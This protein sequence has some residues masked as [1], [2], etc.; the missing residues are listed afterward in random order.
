M[1]GAARSTSYYLEA[2][3][4]LIRQAK[5]PPGGGGV[6]PRRRGSFTGGLRASDRFESVGRCNKAAALLE[7]AGALYL[8]V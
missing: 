6:L 5:H 3:H 1:A 8:R 2:V 4:D 7:G